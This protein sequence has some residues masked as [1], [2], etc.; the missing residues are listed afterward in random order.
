VS[1]SYE[2]RSL[3]ARIRGR[4]SREDHKPR[5]PH[6]ADEDLMVLVGGGDPHAFAALYDRYFRLAYSVAHKLSGEKW[7]AEDLTQDAFLKVWRSAESYRPGRGSVKTWI[8][9]VVRNQNIDRLRARASRR[10]M[11]EK[12]EASAASAPRYE[13][14]EAFAK[15]WHHARLG[16]LREALEALPHGQQQALELAHFSGLTH[17][18]IAECLGLPPGTV[19]GRIRLGLEKLRN[20]TE[21]RGVAAG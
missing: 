3:R 5:Y 12:V 21:L 14:S 4:V 19:K 1:A 11:R 10:R 13:P 9:S 8:L 7:A 20:D 2:I 15:V 17:T 16:R 18:E 6:L